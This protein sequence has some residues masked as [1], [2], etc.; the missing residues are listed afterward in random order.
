MV[1]YFDGRTDGGLDGGSDAAASEGADPPFP[2]LLAAL[3]AFQRRL[4]GE[5]TG[6]MR[7]HGA[8]LRGSHGR[9]LGVLPPEGARPSALAE[10]WISR[11]AIGQRIHEMA[12]A[13]L[14]SVEP[15][16][17]DRR[18]MI[19]RRTA[20]GDRLHSVA[21]EQIAEVEAG[22]AAEVG[23]ERYRVFRDVLEELA[24]GGM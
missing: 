18:A 7:P 1:D 20:E 13:G 2:H 14:V 10:G 15:D 4:G 17:D 11:Q 3:D 9:I 8:R 23:A 6:R 21:N 24:V 12:E 16:P 5:V 22:L 19:V